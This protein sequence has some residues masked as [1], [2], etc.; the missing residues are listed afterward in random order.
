[1]SIKDIAHKLLKYTD[2]GRLNGIGLE[3]NKEEKIK[4]LNSVR[5]KTIDFSKR[6]EK[7]QNGIEKLDVKLNDLES[8]I[9]EQQDQLKEL[10]EKPIEN[11]EIKYLPKNEE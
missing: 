6:K 8:Q 5:Q 7:L 10:I 2:F 4:D 3:K 1:M 9:K 11:Q